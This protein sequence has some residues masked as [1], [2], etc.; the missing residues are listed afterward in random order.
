MNLTVTATDDAGA[1]VEAVVGLTVTDDSVLE[2]IEKREQAPR[3]PVMVLLEPD[4]RELADAHVYLDPANPE[5]PLALDLL[6]GTQGWRR[7]ALVRA[8]EFLQRA[9][10]RRAAACWRMRMVT[11]RE[12]SGGCEACARRSGGSPMAA[13]P[14]TGSGQCPAAA[15]MPRLR[16]P[17][18]RR[19]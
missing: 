1:P 17:A 4:V 16:L 10:R 9:R 18:C 12:R 7:F 15:A 6:L 8:A 3:L 2:M 19:R 14:R 13:V 5:A 11:R